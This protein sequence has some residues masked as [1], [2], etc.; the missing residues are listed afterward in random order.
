M[1]KKQEF[2]TQ[3]DIDVAWDEVARLE[4]KI[5]DRSF[6]TRE[7]LITSLIGSTPSH[8]LS[9]DGLV[10]TA[11]ELMAFIEGGVKAQTAVNTLIKTATGNKRGRPPKGSINKTMK[12]LKAPTGKKKRK[13]TKRSSYWK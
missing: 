13:Y 10:R 9:T 7:H 8:S 2:Y 6:R 4:A 5:E 3:E 1:T 11:D 12:A